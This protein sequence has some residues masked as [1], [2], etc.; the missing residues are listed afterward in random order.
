MN[1]ESTPNS[2]L[3]KLL[4]VLGRIEWVLDSIPKVAGMSDGARQTDGPAAC[5]WYELMKPQVIAS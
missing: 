1:N 5:D 2:K 4:R 3:T